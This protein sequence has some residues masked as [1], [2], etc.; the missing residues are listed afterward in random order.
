M[1][2][3]GLGGGCSTKKLPDHEIPRIVGELLQRKEDSAIANRHLNVVRGD[4]R[5]GNAL[6]P[7]EGLGSLG[8]GSPP[9]KKVT[10]ELW[11]EIPRT[12]KEEFFAGN[13]CHGEAASDRGEK[14]SAGEMRFPDRGAGRGLGAVGLSVNRRYL[15]VEEG[16]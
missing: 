14:L 13:V 6:L 11:Y 5:Q 4:F 2:S 9:E 1:E 3:Q 16:S 7:A 10:A 8:D 15:L 12:V